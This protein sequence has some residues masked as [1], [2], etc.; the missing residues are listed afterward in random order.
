ML[1]KIL[2]V[3]IDLEYYTQMNISKRNH[4]LMSKEFVY[5][6]FK[7]KGKEAKDEYFEFSDKY[8]EDLFSDGYW[9]MND[10]Y[11]EPYIIDKQNFK[12]LIK[13]T[14]DKNSPLNDIQNLDVNKIIGNKQSVNYG[15]EDWKGK[16]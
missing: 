15:I 9:E 7:N 12:N 3:I 2:K 14:P 6:Y 4:I 13:K 11:G 16:P 5:D 8:E 1:V 10:E